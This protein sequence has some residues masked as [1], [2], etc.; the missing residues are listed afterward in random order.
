MRSIPTR[1]ITCTVLGGLRAWFE[2]RWDEAGTLYGL[3][4]ETT[5]RLRAGSHVSCH[6]SVVPRED[7]QQNQGFA[8]L[9]NWIPFPPATAR[10]WLI[11]IYVKGDYDQ[12]Q[13][14][15]TVV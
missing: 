3:R 2:Y 8:A 9:P 14:I 4:A 6:G 11:F 13:S 7:L 15:S 5:T 1:R 10:A 12:P